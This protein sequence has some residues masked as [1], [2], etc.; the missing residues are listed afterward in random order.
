MMFFLEKNVS[1]GTKRLKSCQQPHLEQFLLLR[2]SDMICKSED[3][4]WHN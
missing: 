3:F 1:P 2:R 4:G